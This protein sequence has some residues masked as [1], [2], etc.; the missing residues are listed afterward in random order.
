MRRFPVTSAAYQRG[1]LSTAQVRIIAEQV[2]VGTEDFFARDEAG[3]V[4]KLVSLSVRDTSAVMRYWRYR[5]EAER[6]A[7]KPPKEPERSEAHLSPVGD[8]WKLDATLGAKD[9]ELVDTAL[10]DA[11]T[12]D[13]DG[14]P[15][16]TL[17]QKRADALVD[18][19]R[20]YLDHR[21]IQQTSP[22]RRSHLGASMTLED[23]EQRRG[24]RLPSGTRL[25]PADVQQ[26][27]CDC[28]IFRVLRGEST[29]LDYGRSTRVVPAALRKVVITRDRHC[30]F[31][32]CD[33]PP[34]WCEVHHH[35]PW[36][37]GGGTDLGNLVLVCSRHHHLLHTP[38]WISTFDDSAV[39][40]V[41]TPEGRV[42][43]SHPPP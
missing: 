17:A 42:L 34:H 19:C 21:D 23:L 40:T 27:L 8:I 18:I 16:R 29:I 38:G 28:D 25:D 9:G 6:D 1:E 41:T 37:R 20:Y 2:S 13:V 33:R 31:E 24:A 35:V 12:D 4:P 36:E 15:V 30:R 32:G 14:E 39:L 22:R 7:G 10:D 5:A 43:Q 3:L 26:M 11:M